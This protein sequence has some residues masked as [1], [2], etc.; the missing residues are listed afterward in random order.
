M[1]AAGEVPDDEAD[2]LPEEEKPS[3]LSVME[4]IFRYFGATPDRLPRFKQDWLRMGGELTAA[5]F[6]YLIS[7]H[8]GDS[9]LTRFHGKHLV[10]ALI[11]VHANVDCMDSHAD[12]SIGWDAFQQQLI[13]TATT[14]PERPIGDE[15]EP[16][17]KMIRLP[18]ALLGSEY[19]PG[20][21]RTIIEA[22]VV[23]DA[24][25]ELLFCE[26]V[27]QLAKGGGVRSKYLATPAEAAETFIRRLSL[28][29]LAGG[30]LIRLRVIAEHTGLLSCATIVESSYSGVSTTTALVVAC[31]KP[32]AEVWSIT[33]TGR[34]VVAKP[35]RELVTERPLLCLG[36]ESIGRDNRRQLFGGCVD[37]NVVVWDAKTWQVR[38]V[39]KA[40]DGAVSGLQLL[41][42]VDQLATVSH[43]H[44]LRLWDVS[45][46]PAS[47]QPSGG[48]RWHS[49]PVVGIVYSQLHQLIATASDDRTA[50]VINPVLSERLCSLI[51]HLYPIVSIALTPDAIITAD[52]RLHV[53]VWEMVRSSCQRCTMGASPHPSPP[54]PCASLSRMSVGDGKSHP[55]RSVRVPQP[56]QTS[57][58]NYT[59]LCGRLCAATA[60]P[61]APSTHACTAPRLSNA[62]PR[63]FAPL[64]Q[65][66]L[67][68]HTRLHNSPL[69]LWRRSLSRVCRHSASRQRECPPE[70]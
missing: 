58:H 69:L 9:E 30:S 70:T 6:M 50:V 39:I 33:V 42:V 14:S 11:Q 5:Q 16:V 41:K 17:P 7:L 8:M 27:P 60:R 26:K 20:P 36:H 28:W 29:R 37:G 55:W 32:G 52:A 35:D 61:A 51:G 57:L 13:R 3:P 43:D 49:R 38:Q 12:G 10:A 21:S 46:E 59:C 47:L 1:P 53:R 67:S 66:V 63:F 54:N 22:M 65:D 64:S 18:V 62:H 48:D 34:I 19:A 2:D 45:E 56:T 25:L 40:H 23:L 24:P 4:E 68:P 15:D 44:T 31:D